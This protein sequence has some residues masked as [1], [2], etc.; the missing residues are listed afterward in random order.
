MR[1]STIEAYFCKK[2]KEHHF[3]TY[4]FKSVNRVAIPDRIV[5]GLFGR[6]YFVE[7]KAPGKKPTAAQT[8][9]ANRLRD[10]RIEVYTIDSKEAVDEHFK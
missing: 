1:E 5:I 9:E 3:L 2:A 4:K 10:R 7:F 6:V 8:R